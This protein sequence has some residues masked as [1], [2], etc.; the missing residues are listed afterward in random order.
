MH[1]MFQ[2]EKKNETRLE[3]ILRKGKMK[4]NEP[5]YYNEDEN[6]DTGSASILIWRAKKQK[7]IFIAGEAEETV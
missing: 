6:N 2:A 7:G 5:Y 1:E 4:V 3:R